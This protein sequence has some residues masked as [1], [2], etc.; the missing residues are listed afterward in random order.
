M[1]IRGVGPHISPGALTVGRL[2]TATVVLTVLLAARGWVR[3][4]RREWLL[5]VGCGLTWFAVYN[6]ALNAAEQVLDAGTTAMLVG[7]GPL[8][9]ALL[10]G[11]FLGEGMPRWLFVGAGVSLVG[12]AII[13]RAGHD[14]R[15]GTTGGVLLAVLAAVMYAT[16]VVLQKL[17][18]RR[19]PA[20]QV[21]WTACAVGLVVCLPFLPTLWREV[22]AAPALSAVGIAYLGIVPTAL[23]FTTWAYALARTAAGPLGTDDVHRARRRDRPCLG[24]PQRG[25]DRMAA[26]RWGGHAAGCRR[27]AGTHGA[28]PAG[29][30]RAGHPAGGVLPLT[31][32]ACRRGQAS[33]PSAG[34]NTTSTARSA[35]TSWKRWTSSAG[36][37]SVLPARTATVVPAAVKL[38][39]PD[40]T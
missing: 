18:L 16:G 32:R 39:A 21:T 13:S 9:I 40:T 36:T 35:V 29:P 20:L 31:P 2:G 27:L 11:L 17:A 34:A 22:A 14:D 1:V 33:A 37:N 10:A 15:A 5:L 3:P 4:T 8:L 12:I 28:F 38:A 26:R 30:A 23:A 24:L 7:I 19:L 25:P 6:L